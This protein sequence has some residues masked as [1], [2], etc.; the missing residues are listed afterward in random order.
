M[1]RFDDRNRAEKL[2]RKGWTYSEIKKELG[3]PK[4]TL[5]GWL[6]DY[7]LT[8]TQLSKLTSR[9][10]SNK[11]LG[12]E[13]TRIVKAKKRSERLRSIYFDEKTRLLPLSNRETYLLGLFLYWGEGVKGMHNTHIGVNNTDPRVLKF[14]LYWLIRSLKVEKKKVRVVLHLYSDMNVVREVTFWSKE[15]GV[16]EK[17]FGKPYIKESR[18]ENVVHKGHRHGTCG[19]YVY[20][21]RL[22]EKVM[23]GIN[24]LADF[25]SGKLVDIIG[26]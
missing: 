25:Y 16:P 19:L 13:K 6:K 4:S 26:D 1:T 24:V 10:K 20:D 2:R 7:Q 17:Q 12:I 15:L 21:A 22:K 5:S 23:S 8:N 9:S 11:L 18:S 14:Y 3:V